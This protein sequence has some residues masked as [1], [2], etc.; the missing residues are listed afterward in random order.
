MNASAPPHAH[1]NA[2][3]DT[4]SVRHKKRAR[5]Q[6]TIIIAAT[7]YTREE[8]RSD[9]RERRALG[10]RIVHT[11]TPKPHIL[12]PNCEQSHAPISMYVCIV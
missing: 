11:H 1:T 2:L 3:T 10:P 6:N 9:V 5:A 4:P 8:Q 7:R 12:T